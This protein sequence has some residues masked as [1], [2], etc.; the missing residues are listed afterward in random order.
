MSFNLNAE[1]QNQAPMVRHRWTNYQTRGKEEMSTL[2]SSLLVHAVAK[3]KRTWQHNGFSC[4][5]HI[6]GTLYPSMLQRPR[7]PTPSCGGHRE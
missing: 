6:K 4:M 3:S 5:A 2:E 7:T 1:A